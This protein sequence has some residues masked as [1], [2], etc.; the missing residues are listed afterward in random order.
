MASSRCLRELPWSQ[1]WGPTLFAALVAMMKS[2]R[3]LA[4]LARSQRPMISSVRP[5][6]STVPPSG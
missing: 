5:A 3:R 2:W 6:V 4:P 1:L